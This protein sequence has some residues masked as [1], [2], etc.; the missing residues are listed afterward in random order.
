MLM[1]AALDAQY[2]AGDVNTMVKPYD[3]EKPYLLLAFLQYLAG[4]QC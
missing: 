4:L 1:T 3:E 2:A